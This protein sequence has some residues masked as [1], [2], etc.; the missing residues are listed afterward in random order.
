VRLWEEKE[1]MPIRRHIHTTRGSVYAFRSE[2]DC[3][4]ASRRPR[5]E[6]RTRRVLLAV[7]PFENLSGDFE[8]EYFSDAITDG[9][10]T[11]LSCWHT[12]QFSVIART[13]A[14][15][16]KGTKKTINEIARELAVNHI[17]DGTVRRSA[18]R[19]RVTA[20]LIQ[21]REQVQVW[22]EDYDHDW[23]E[24]F[25]IQTKVAQQIAQSLTPLRQIEPY[26]LR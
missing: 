14:M 17:L 1:G 22:A 19:V 26:L 4:R 3:W 13:S 11:Q 24:G 21:V 20:R 9:V 10:I 12:Q 5:N 6:V 23:A 16:Y 8:Q 18:G 2:L 7:L 25:A 15:I